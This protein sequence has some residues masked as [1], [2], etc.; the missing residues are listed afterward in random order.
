M[1]G[2]EHG[3][4]L[5][6]FWTLAIATVQKV[7]PMKDMMTNVYLLGLGSDGT[8]LLLASSTLDLAGVSLGLGISLTL[9]N[10]FEVLV[11]LSALCLGLAHLERAEVTLALQAL[12][13]NQT[14]DLGSLG[15]WLGTLLLGSDLSAD[16]KVA[17][18]VLLGKVEELA[19]VVS[20]LGTKTL[21]HDRLGVSQTGDVL[22]TLLDNDEVK[23][24]HVGTNN[25]TA[26][27][28][29][30]ALSS[31]TLTVARSVFA[32]QKTDTVR[33]KDTCE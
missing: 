32:K 28:F 4:S 9:S 5:A 20:A 23:G 11:L 19:D 8:S 3:N 2:K 12:T 10:K 7:Y 25:A 22:F 15:V 18:I 27:G 1:N 29:T 26:D 31:T 33:Y 16:D 14:L 13:S 21:G 24:L 17:N 6:G 30:A